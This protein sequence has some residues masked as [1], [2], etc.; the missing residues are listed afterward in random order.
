MSRAALDS[1]LQSL[2]RFEPREDGYDASGLA[3]FS[4]GER[5]MAE[6]ALIE[7]AAN[8]DARALV[9]IGRLGLTRALDV[10]HAQ[11]QSRWGWVR[12]AAHRALLRLV[13][14]AAAPALVADAATGS[15]TARFGA[16]VELA[17]SKGPGAEQALLDGLQ[18]PDVLVRSRALES[19][20]ERYGLRGYA[21]DEYGQTALETPLMTIDCMLSSD[22]VPLWIQGAHEA[23]AIFEALAAGASPDALGLR[24]VRGG[25][26]GFRDDVREAF[27]DDDV[28]FDTRPIAAVSGHDRLWAETFLAMQLARRSVRAARA[29]ADLGARWT[30]PALEASARGLPAGD[31]FGAAVAAALETLRA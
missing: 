7:R 27:F 4:D 8:G 19:L 31:P 23:R 14:D 15:P 25:P 26:R 22:V 24:Y 30:V 17:T 6:D 5:A 29:L 16:M 11:S 10:V 21:L 28:R 3:S 9:T 12:F 2:R 13:G 20:I 18:D 1:F